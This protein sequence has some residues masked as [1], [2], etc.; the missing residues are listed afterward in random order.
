[1]QYVT[2]WLNI[3]TLFKDFEQ[4][5]ENTHEQSF[6]AFIDRVFMDPEISIP[7]ASRIWPQVKAAIFLFLQMRG[8]WIPLLE[9]QH[10][11]SSSS[12]DNHMIFILQSGINKHL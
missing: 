11:C 4:K 6:C 12:R 2:T 7:I 9:T 10:P 8:N 1:M 3:A 5:I